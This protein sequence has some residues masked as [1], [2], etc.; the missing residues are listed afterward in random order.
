MIDRVAF[1]VFGHPIYWYGIIIAIGLL[2]AIL[3]AMYHA[4][5]EG[6]NPDNILDLALIVV[7]LAVICAR[8]YYVVFEWEKYAPPMPFWHV[9][10]VWEGGLA[11]YGGVIGGFIGVWIYSKFI[12]KKI[13]FVNLLD[14]LAP[15]LILGQ[16]IGRW[17]NFVNQE[18]FGRIIDDP[19]WQ[20][21]PAAVF[22]QN[23]IINN[24]AQPAGYYM[25]TFFYESIWNF[26]VFGFLFFYYKNSKTRRKGN[27]FWFYLL[28]YG[29]GRVVIEGLRTDSLYIPGT[30][31][32]ASQVLSGVLIVVSAIV[33]LFPNIKTLYYYVKQKVD[34]RREDEQNVPLDDALKLIID[35]GSDEKDERTLE[36]SIAQDEETDKASQ[37]E[38]ASKNSPAVDE[39]PEDKE[40]Q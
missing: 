39:L 38:R 16:A 7:P 8:I 21:F 22:I 24:V 13:A 6:H 32:R 28:L 29:L 10:A 20:W 26:L 25:A 30:D 31:I 14:L 35:D 2:L 12:N 18:A 1:S 34:K 5:R 19:S 23:P 11:I 9:F 17:G 3:L 4:R 37:P 36:E 40:D 27:I 15:S 33:L